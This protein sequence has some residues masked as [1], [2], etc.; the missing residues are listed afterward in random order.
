M[1]SRRGVRGGG[2]GLGSRPPSGPSEINKDVISVI[3]FLMI[4][5]SF[6]RLRMENEPQS[7]ALPAEGFFYH[8]Q[9]IPQQ[10]ISIQMF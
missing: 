5:Y 1:A 3:K 7:I 4:F 2:Q 8:T 10:Q 6:T 9:P